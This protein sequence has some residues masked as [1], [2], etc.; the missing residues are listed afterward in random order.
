MLR[1]DVW[2]GILQRPNVLEGLRG[3]E[4]IAHS[5]AG[6][7]VGGEQERAPISGNLRDALREAILECDVPIEEKGHQRRGGCSHGEGDG[8][9]GNAPPIVDP[10]DTETRINVYTKPKT[11]HRHTLPK[12]AGGKT[13]VQTIGNQ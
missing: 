11:L 5:F 9:T 12:G 10:A 13:K 6:G 2:G 8:P 7:D 1:A 4:T 3:R